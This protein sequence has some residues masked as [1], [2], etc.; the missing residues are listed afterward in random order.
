MLDYRRLRKL[1]L[2]VAMFTQQHI[3]D[4]RE[5]SR[6][7]TRGGNELDR[8]A[9]HIDHYSLARGA[10][11]FDAGLPCRVDARCASAMHGL[12]RNF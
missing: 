11:P 7:D 10:E 8:H 2:A 6:Y 3:I 12:L 4:A 5:Q 1:E 9:V